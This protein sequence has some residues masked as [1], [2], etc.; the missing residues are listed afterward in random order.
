MSIFGILFLG[1]SFY[2]V[3]YGII[4]LVERGFH[5]YDEDEDE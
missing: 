3:V 2:V 1:F 5:H 4:K